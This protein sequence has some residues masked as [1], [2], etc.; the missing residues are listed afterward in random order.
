MHPKER[1]VP[2]QQEDEGTGRDQ[3]AAENDFEAYAFPEQ[4]NRKQYGEGHAE[5]VDGGDFGNV[6]KL[7]R[8]EIKQP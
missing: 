1:R 3:R 7:Q 8:L 2:L 6:P 5:L 4:Q